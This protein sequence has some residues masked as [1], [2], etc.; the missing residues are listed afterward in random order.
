M[1]VVA[2]MAMFPMTMMVD[3]VFCIEPRQS[4]NYFVNK[5]EHY[6]PCLLQAAQWPTKTDCWLSS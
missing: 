3:V 5:T 6:R 4:N 1:D 2:S